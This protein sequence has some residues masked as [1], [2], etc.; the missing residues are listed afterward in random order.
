VKIESHPSSAPD[1]LVLEAADPVITHGV[2]LP[3]DSTM[4]R[5]TAS[6]AGSLPK[7]PPSGRPPDRNDRPLFAQY[8]SADSTSAP[9]E[10]PTASPSNPN[11]CSAPLLLDPERASAGNTGSNCNTQSP[12]LSRLYLP[13]TLSDTAVGL[14]PMQSAEARGS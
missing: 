9:T 4:G 5:S 2:T 1:P 7:V 11:A 12:C 10:A 14:G 3:R 6:H 8:V 13:T